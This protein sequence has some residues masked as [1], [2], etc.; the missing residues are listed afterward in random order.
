MMS[1]LEDL[2]ETR[3]GRRVLLGLCFFLILCCKIPE[4]QT[5]N[6][7]LERIYPMVSWLVLVLR[8]L[9]SFKL[10]STI[11]YIGR[12]FVKSFFD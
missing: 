8:L 7:G 9:G 4:L 11:T 1:S 6:A 10:A 5:I 12:F 2:S 3:R